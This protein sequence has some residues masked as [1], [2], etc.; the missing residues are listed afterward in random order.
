MDKPRANPPKKRGKLYVAAGIVGAVIITAALSQLDPAPPSV[1][2]EIAWMDTVERGP[3][4]RQVRGAGTLVPEHAQLISAITAGRIEQVFVDPGTMVEQGQLL[5]KLTNPDVQLQLLEAQ[6]SLSNAMTTLLNLEVTLKQ[7]R[8]TQ[9]GQIATLL[10]QYSEAVRQDS[11][12][13][14]LMQKD[15]ITRNVY[16]SGK[17]LVR[18]LKQRHEAEGQN[19]AILDGSMQARLD[20]GQ[21][22]VDRLEQIVQFRTVELNSMEVRAPSGGV[23]QRLGPPGTGRLEIGQYVTPG[24]EIARIVQPDRLKAELRIPETQMVDVTLGQD[25][26]IDTRNGVVRGTVVRIDPAAQNGTVGVDV[27]LPETLPAGAR[28]DLSVD[29]RIVV[30]QLEDVLYMNRPNVA[31]ANSTI[32]LFKLESDGRT[33][34][35]VSVQIGAASVNE[36]E[37]AGGLSEGDVV[38]LSDMSQWDNYDRIRLR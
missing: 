12:N 7:S 14:E 20:A 3:M 5:I 8:L 36:V 32:G 16:L 28:P 10:T 24:T 2:R 17:D 26:E 27:K 13:E 31:A 4:T 33:A 35:R 19:L 38:I 1:E 11:V 23:L 29:G 25:A 9:Q 34:V 6:R 37:V 22:E 21:S 15:L 18:E 30:E